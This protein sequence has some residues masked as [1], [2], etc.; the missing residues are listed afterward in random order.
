MKVK[1]INDDF[2][3][4]KEEILKESNG[5]PIT[6]P[7]KGKEYTI[8][9]TFDN[10]GIVTSYLLQEIYNPIFYIPVIQQK[11]ELSFAEWRFETI[12]ENQ[13]ITVEEYERLFHN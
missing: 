7:V 13:K 4:V 9:E 12:F 8:R 5:L 2:S 1:C 10:D 3:K 6:F 11:R